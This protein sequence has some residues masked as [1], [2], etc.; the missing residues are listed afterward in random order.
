MAK[1]IGIDFG[2]Q[3]SGNSVIA[4]LSNDQVQFIQVAKKQHTDSWLKSMLE[5]IN[6]E[7]VY[8]DAPLSIPS[9]YHGQGQNFHYR[10]ADI[11]TSAMSPMFLGG[12]TARAMSLKNSF[13]T[14]A[15]YEV[16]PAFFQSK[17]IK[18]THYKKDIDLFL[19]KLLEK[20]PIHLND[21]PTNWHQI[22]ALMALLSGLRHQNNK[23]LEMGDINEGIIII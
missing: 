11:E 3:L 6:P 8:I 7:S 20:T 1:I 22:D 14:V 13:K 16:Y 5:E 10:K 19:L 21:T 17:L 2:A 4:H 15:F 18:S 9:A 12:L 23:H